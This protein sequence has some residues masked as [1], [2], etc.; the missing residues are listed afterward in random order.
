[1]QTA[2]L[3]DTPEVMAVVLPD[4]TT[5]DMQNDYVATGTMLLVRYADGRLALEP[6]S[7]PSAWRETFQEKEMKAA[8]GYFRSTKPILDPYSRE[9]VG[10]EMELKQLPIA[11]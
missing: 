5:H 2:E 1:M 10:Y 3:P 4:G 11:S 9:V 7:H 8:A 6:V